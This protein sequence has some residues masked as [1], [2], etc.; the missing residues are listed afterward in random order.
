VFGTH[1]LRVIPTGSTY[2][3]IIIFIFKLPYETQSLH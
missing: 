2:K 1:Y 3:T